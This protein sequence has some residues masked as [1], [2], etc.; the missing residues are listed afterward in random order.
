MLIT[1]RS[2]RPSSDGCSR[3]R[4]TAWRCSRSPRGTTPLRLRRWGGPSSAFSSARAILTAW[5]H[6]IR[7]RKS[8]AARIS[9]PPAGRPGCGPTAPA[10]CTPT[11]RGRRSP[12]S[13]SCSAGWRPRCA[14]SR[15]TITGTIRSVGASFSTRAQISSSTAWARAQRSRPQ[16]ACATA[17]P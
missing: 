11:A 8:A 17:S 15:I 10:P 3:T 14:G 6:T 2:A 5:S 1:R 7:R 12:A 4:A 16:T 13:P 9:I